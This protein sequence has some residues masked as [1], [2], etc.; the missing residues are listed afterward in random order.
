PAAAPQRE[1]GGSSVRPEVRADRGAG[2]PGCWNGKRSRRGLWFV[3][4]PLL[5]GSR[6]LL[7][8]VEDPASR[9]PDGRAGRG[10]GRGRRARRRGPSKRR[11]RAGRQPA[12]GRGQRRRAWPGPCQLFLLV[13]DRTA[14]LPLAFPPRAFDL[15][16][17][18][19]LL[20]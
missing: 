13:K 2:Y 18:N 16:G 6:P 10:P 8:V 4:G 20:P 17:I 7:V 19:R 5:R 9:T 1:D 12:A 11:P 15:P 3:G 14:P